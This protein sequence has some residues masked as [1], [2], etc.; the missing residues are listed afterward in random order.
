MGEVNM[1]SRIRTR[2]Y[3]SVRGRSPNGL[4]LLDRS[5]KPGS[6]GAVHMGNFK[7]NRLYFHYSFY[8]LSAIN[9]INVIFIIQ[10]ADM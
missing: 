5:L 1:K 4:L 9:A 7:F 2:T 6:F 10:I 8:R 3:G